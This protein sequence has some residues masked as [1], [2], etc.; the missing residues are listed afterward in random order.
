MMF[1]SS[2]QKL[3]HLNI[4]DNLWNRYSFT[5]TKTFFQVTKML[6]KKYPTL[7]IIYPIVQSLL[8]YLMEGKKW[9]EDADIEEVRDIL[10]IRATE[11]KVIGVV[12]DK[13]EQ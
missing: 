4:N 5:I 9:K 6:S 8:Y 13:L 2:D 10:F 1:V 7:S 11:I 12:V 3:N